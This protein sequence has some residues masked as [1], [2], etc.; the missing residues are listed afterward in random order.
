V[1]GVRDRE[2]RNFSRFRPGRPAVTSLEYLLRID[3]QVS[4]IRDIMRL[5]GIVSVMLAACF[6]VPVTASAGSRAVEGPGFAF[7]VPDGV[8]FRE[9][10]SLPGGEFIPADSLI[11]RYYY[12]V[13]RMETF[14]DQWPEL[15]TEDFIKKWAVHTCAADGPG[16]SQHCDGD[17]LVLEPF[18]SGHGVT[19]YKVRRTR[20]AEKYGD[21]GT[22]REKFTDLIIAFD[23]KDRLQGKDRLAA[24][25]CEDKS[26]FDLVQTVGKSF[27]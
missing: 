21:D 26:C 27:R 3:F 18:V 19:G 1:H 12:A 13:L 2:L 24:F 22:E 9:Y 5:S 23:I 14:W 17:S 10:P 4:Y 20:I 15:G 7:D 25:I 11:N 6:L 16:S 8:V